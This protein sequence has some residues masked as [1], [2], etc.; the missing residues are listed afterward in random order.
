MATELGFRRTPYWNNW[1]IWYG[2]PYVKVC[3]NFDNVIWVTIAQFPIV[4]IP[5]DIASILKLDVANCL[6]HMRKM[7]LSAYMKT[8]KFFLVLDDMWSTLDLKELGVEFRE[9]KGSK[10]GFT[11][12]NRD[13]EI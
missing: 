1:G 6:A 12:R 11:T 4:H 5:N 9:N 2:L 10:F 7:K 13:L 3:H 8:K